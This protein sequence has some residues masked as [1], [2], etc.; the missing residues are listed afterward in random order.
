MSYVWQSLKRPEVYLAGLFLLIALFVAD[1]FRAPDR[2][3]S[4]WLYIGVVRVYQVVGRPIANNWIECRYEPTCSE[5]SIQ[6][7]RLYGL[8]QGWILT[9]DRVTACRTD[10]P[11]GTLDPVPS[12]NP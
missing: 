1:T 7:V 5:Y 8:R 12:R 10:V 4:G 6:A 11:K 3:I 2:Q 9:Y